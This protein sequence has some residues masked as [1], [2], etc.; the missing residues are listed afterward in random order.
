MNNKKVLFVLA[1][2]TTGG[3]CTSMLNLLEILKSKGNKIDLFLMSRD[4]ELINQAKSVSNLIDEE[5]IISSI[6]SSK[7]S[8][9]KEFNF[10]KLVIRISY[11]IL[12]KVFGREQTTN[13][14]YNVSA[15]RLSDRYDAIIAY[16]ESMTTEYVKYIKAKLKIAWV[17]NDYD[18]FSL[19]KSSLSI[20]RTYNSFH[21]IVCVSMSVKLSM[22]INLPEYHD[23]IKLVY[24]TFM[25]DKIIAASNEPHNLSRK[26]SDFILVSV[27][28]FSEQ[29]GFSRIV[30]VAKML[31]NEGYNFSWYLVG[32]GELWESLK[33]RINSN[34][35]QNTVV[36]L[37]RLANPFPVVK[38]SDYFVLTSNY[39]AHPM[40]VNEA[41]I[42]GKPVISTAF[43][44]V[45]EVLTDGVT[46][47]ICE[48]S[49]E[50][51][52]YGIKRMLS[53]KSLNNQIINNVRCFEYSND[54]II[55]QVIDL[56][57]E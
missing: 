39:E 49:I 12:H 45:S 28:R 8:V 19:G 25:P 21:K 6:T 32:D 5:I 56:I 18:K 48:N 23:R 52:Y 7:K 22:K 41:L 37:G 55:S 36:L 24:N 2:A 11:V 57:Y 10:L 13:F 51:L 54:K 38:F 14:F 44:S 46:G 29:K 9:I 30:D 42:L 35:L 50:G 16:Q 20:K 3:S 4:G 17:H 27:G 31:L 34:K 1:K 33:N 40:V 43:N 15:K 47:I 53:N 26:G